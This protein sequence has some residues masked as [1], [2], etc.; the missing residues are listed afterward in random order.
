MLAV[1]RYNKAIP[2]WCLHLPSLNLGIAAWS[3]E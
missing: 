1:T 3:L 2:S